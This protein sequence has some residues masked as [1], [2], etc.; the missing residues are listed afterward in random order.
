[1]EQQLDRRLVGS[2]NVIQAEHERPLFR[3]ELEQRA[4]RAM[5]G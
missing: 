5:M 1:V 4:H 2:V 3:E